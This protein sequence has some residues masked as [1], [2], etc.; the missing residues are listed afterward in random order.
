ML[1]DRIDRQP[2]DLDTALVELRLDLGHV[3]ELGGA[4]RREVLRMREQHGPGA[5]DPVV[6]ADLAFRGLSLEVGSGIV[7]GKGHVAPPALPGPAACSASGC[8]NHRC[9]SRLAGRR[10][11]NF[12]SKLCS[13]GT[14]RRR[15]CSRGIDPGMCLA[16]AR[17]EDPPACA[18]I[19]GGPGK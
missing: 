11:P 13:P 17:A 8:C 12:P 7:D 18:T 19:A 5:A 10:K 3:A 6:E 15:R 2:D 14:F 1:L 9:K 4:H 16:G